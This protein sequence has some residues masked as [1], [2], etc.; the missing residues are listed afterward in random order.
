VKFESLGAFAAHL[1]ARQAKI[2]VEIREGLHIVAE[3]VEKT[4]IQKIGEYQGESGQFPAWA[5]LA[6]S[7]E[8]EKAR[9]GYPADAPLLREGDLRDSI[10]HEVTGLDA[11]VGSTSPIAPF[12]EFGTSKMPP[13]P[14]IGPAAFERK[15][16]IETVLGAVLVAGVTDGRRVH[17]ESDFAAAGR[18]EE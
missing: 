3:A 15:K 14:F 11:V 4:A 10:S 17:V 12:Q 6:E 16:E 8:A 7:T 5:T 18:V 13:R 2:A 1:A 9:L